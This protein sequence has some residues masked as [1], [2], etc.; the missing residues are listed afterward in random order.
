MPYNYYFEDLRFSMTPGLSPAA[1]RGRRSSS[2]GGGP[3]AGLE[4]SSG[5]VELTGIEPAT[6]ALQGRRSPS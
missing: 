5:M 3:A 1:A 6:S 4:I 2:P